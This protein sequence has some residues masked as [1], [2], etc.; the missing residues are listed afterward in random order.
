[1]DADRDQLRLLSTFHY[2]VAVLAGC[3]ACFPMI[4]LFV[5]IKV[6]TDPT[7][8][9]GPGGQNA[10][11]QGFQTIFG[12]MFTLIPLAM[13]VAG[14]IFT[15]CLVIAGNNLRRQTRYTFCLVVA[16][17][18]CMF[19]PFGTVLGVFTIIV[20]LRPSVKSLFNSQQNTTFHS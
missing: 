6:L 19:I 8:F 18:G 16:A 11:P 7:F 5:G 3:M 20:L 1:M 2:V 4:H 12:L 13:I 15:I 17:I 9:N 10:P 14:W